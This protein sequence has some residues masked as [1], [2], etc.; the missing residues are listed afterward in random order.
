M[1]YSDGA[2]I[3]SLEKAAAFYRDNGFRVCVCK[4]GSVIP[5][6]KKTIEFDGEKEVLV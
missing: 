3:P 5:K 4:K 6:T 1:L 2:D